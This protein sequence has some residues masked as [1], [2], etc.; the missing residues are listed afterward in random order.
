MA[1][2]REHPAVDPERLF[3]VGYSHGAWTLLEAL[4]LGEA[5]PPG[6]ADRPARVWHGLR[7]AVAWY[8]YCGAAA[9]FVTDSFP[10]LPVLML[11][12]EKDEITAPEPCADSAERLAGQGLPVRYEV[13]PGVS[14]GFDRDEA[15]V[16]LYIPAMAERAIAEQFA[17][18]E[19]HGQ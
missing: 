15:W 5:L 14:H 13:F 18:V 6:L 16:R 11:L 8:P 12:A 4:A 19:H 10:A 7:G 2:A 9:S 1:V 3:L 17:F